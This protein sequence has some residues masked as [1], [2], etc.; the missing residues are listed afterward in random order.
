MAYEYYYPGH[1]GFKPAEN[2]ALHNA[3]VLHDSA[4]PA[5]NPMNLLYHTIATWPD[6]QLKA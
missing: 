5:D 2:G 3:D 4:L 1:L 6:L